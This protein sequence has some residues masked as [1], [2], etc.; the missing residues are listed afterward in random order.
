VASTPE[1][2]L[3]T[4]IVKA[5]KREHPTAWTFTVVGSPYQRSG[6]PDLLVVLDGHLYAFEVKDQKPGESAEHAYG[7]ATALQRQQINAIRNAGGT[8]HVVLSPEEALSKLTEH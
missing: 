6:V 2:K 1:G 3:Q 7:R 8:A 5:I 4:K